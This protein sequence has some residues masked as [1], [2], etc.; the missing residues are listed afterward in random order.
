MGASKSRK[1]HLSLMN[2]AGFALTGQNILESKVAQETSQEIAQLI[3]QLSSPLSYRK[4]MKTRREY[5]ILLLSQYDPNVD[6][7][8][9]A[10]CIHG[11]L[12]LCTFCSRPTKPMW[13]FEIG[14][15]YYPPLQSTFFVEFEI[16]VH[17]VH[18][19]WQSIFQIA[20]DHWD[21][22]VLQVW[23]Y[24]G[25]YRL[26]VPIQ[27][28]D[29]SSNHYDKDPEVLLR[30]GVKT[31][32][33]IEVDIDVGQRIYFNGEMVSDNST[34]PRAFPYDQK[35][36]VWLCHNQH[37]PANVTVQ[38]FSTDLPIFINTGCI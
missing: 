24:P 10:D 25:S 14:H 4:R 11:F 29:G 35:K 13:N 30:R 33:R 36:K 19:D 5:L 34:C 15:L 18:T 9:I 37:K 28:R 31:Y 20:N 27:A 12:G 17:N 21:R 32:I 3:H 7:S 22:N 16:T 6:F 8:T 26:H 1:N 23:L 2:Q 38:N